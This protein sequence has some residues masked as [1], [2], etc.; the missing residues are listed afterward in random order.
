MQ[1]KCIVCE[2]EM[3]Y[4]V[5]TVE[6]VEEQIATFLIG[7]YLHPDLNEFSLYESYYSILHILHH[8][9]QKDSKSHKPYVELKLITVPYTFLKSFIAITK[10]QRIKQNSLS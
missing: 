7:N 5:S 8:L 4:N 6:D 9:V 3:A 1:S 2:A 10:L